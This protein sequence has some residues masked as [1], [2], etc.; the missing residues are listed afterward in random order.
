[1]NDFTNKRTLNFNNK[2]RTINIINDNQI[3]TNKRTNVKEI[4]AE[5]NRKDIYLTNKGMIMKRNIK[6]NQ[7]LFIHHKLTRGRKGK[8]TNIFVWQ[9]N[10]RIKI[11]GK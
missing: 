10:I 7:I 8:T 1:M 11:K 9:I 2:I 4:K 5:L 3:Y 6:C